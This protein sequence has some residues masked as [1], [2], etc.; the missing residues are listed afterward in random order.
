MAEGCWADCVLDSSEPSD[1]STVVG[2]P[3]ASVGVTGCR[4]DE[5]VAVLFGVT[6]CRLG[7]LLT[8]LFGL[9]Q[10]WIADL[11]A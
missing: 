11:V 2:D 8:S 1:L 6:G 5:L 4:L 10:S 9:C 7:G 3:K